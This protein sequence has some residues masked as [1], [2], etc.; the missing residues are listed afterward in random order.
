M[1]F[2]LFFFVTLFVYFI[3]FYLYMKQGLVSTGGT[4]G[5][6]QRLGEDTKTNKFMATE[7]L[8]TVYSSLLLLFFSSIT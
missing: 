3:L 1:F 4:E 7:R 5:Y 8:P 6:L 2:V